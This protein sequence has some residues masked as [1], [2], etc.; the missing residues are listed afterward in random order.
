MP[1]APTAADANLS[2][3]PA[4]S[5]TAAHAGRP[6][7]AL[8]D[9]QARR[10]V[11]QVGPLLTAHA[12]NPRQHRPFVHD[13][14]RA[15]Y[16]ATGRTYS[17]AF[18]RRLLGA[19]APGRT[20]S[21]ATIETER[22]LLEL[23]LSRGLT[24]P[25]AEPA[26]DLPAPPLAP[27]TPAEQAAPPD[28]VPPQTL[29]LLQQLA[30]R[31]EQVAHAPAGADR[32][33]GLQAHN[34]YLAQR[35]TAVET[36]LASARAHAAALAAQ[37]RAQSSLADERSRQIAALQVGADKHAEALA[38]IAKAAEGQRLFALRAM[39]DVRGET[40]E[41]KERCAHLQAQLKEKEQQVEQYRQLAMSR[42]GA[43][44]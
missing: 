17:A 20:P 10:L 3:A 16:H 36:E 15:V 41:V 43:A 29:G 40:R 32:T 7:L 4:R 34:D 44:R 24:Q 35:L 39:D 11:L 12:H 6:R 26:P 19:Y 9:E 33:S 38:A 14:V 42:G 25:I 28:L 23:E 1:P 2:A 21:T 5:A 30:A 31:L 18:Y 13:F 22:Q 37:L 8:S 27:T